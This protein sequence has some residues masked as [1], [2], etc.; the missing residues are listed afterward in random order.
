MNYIGDLYGK[1]NG[2]YIKLGMTS[3]DVDLLEKEKCELLGII[4]KKDEI[5]GKMKNC[6]D[7]KNFGEYL[8]CVKIDG[9]NRTVA[10]KKVKGCGFLEQCK[11]NELG[12]MKK[13]TFEEWKADNS[14]EIE[15]LA[16]YF[17]MHDTEDYFVHDKYLEAYEKIELLCKAV[18]DRE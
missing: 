18:F 9:T 15:D 6:D 14:H 1:V 8:A 11:N 12:E 16:D 2:K 4:Q 10:R 17:M 3:S 13:K 5:I 7:C